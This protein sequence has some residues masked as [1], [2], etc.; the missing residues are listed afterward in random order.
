MIEQFSS[1]TVRA[2]LVVLLVVGGC[3]HAQSLR[4]YVDAGSVF[5]MVIG[6]DGS[7]WTFGKNDHGQLGIGEVGPPVPR[8]VRAEIPQGVRIAA[9]SGGSNHALAVDTDGGLWAWGRNQF[10]Q[11]LA[12]PGATAVSPQPV[13]MPNEDG[14]PVRFVAVSA[15]YEISAAIDANGGLWTWGSSTHG[16]LGQGRLVFQTE[17]RPQR[18]VF[19]E[20][21]SVAQV[22][23]GQTHSLALDT[24]GRI[25]SWGLN[26]RGQLGN[27]RAHADSVLG[28][29]YTPEL[30]DMPAG[31]S[32]SVVAAGDQFSIAVDRAGR[33]WA[34]GVNGLGQL[35]TGTTG[36]EPK[37]R[38]VAMPWGTRFSEVASGDMFA[39]ALDTD[40]RVW[41]WGWNALGQLGVGGG[42]SVI[43]TPAMSVMP[44][45]VR[46]LTISA[47]F[48][49][50]IALDGLGRLWAWGFN[51]EGE[52]GTGGSYSVVP[53]LVGAF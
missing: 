30:V 45:G 1:W 44:Q 35:G 32:F 25:W 10:G 42:A 19:P 49:H 27:G 2:G 48:Q 22:S 40:G 12:Q 37:P 23:V 38:Q 3:S 14:R 51:G 39:L 50:G 11:A 4:N 17:G 8:P 36:D 6:G 5:S 53:V 16:G 18:V 41:G 46:F 29:V 20:P 28:T 24:T 15:G 21:V 52:L 34:W 26:D 43:S 13:P 7:V 9:V 31:T 47:G 33:A